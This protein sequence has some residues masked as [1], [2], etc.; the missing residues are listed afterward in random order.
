M[1]DLYA[2]LGVARG[3][4][5]TALKRAYRSKAKLLHPDTVGGD[6]DA[7]V[8]LGK[9][10]R[11]LSDSEMRAHYDATG[12]VDEEAFD[13]AER[14]FRQIL[15]DGFQQVVSAAG[16]RIDEIDII[17]RLKSAIEENAQRAFTEIQ[18]AK[19][20]VGKLQKLKSRITRDD[21]GRNFF[22][23]ALNSEIGK[24]DAAIRQAE[25][26]R[27]IL[28]LCLDEV[29]NYSSIVEMVQTMSFMWGSGSSTGT[30]GGVSWVQIA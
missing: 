25:R 3:C 18:G 21:G 7:F 23:D 16:P 13:R 20:Q 4:D 29:R 8:E 17:A 14:V 1:S 10:F 24:I 27:E 15:L 30:G 28:N 6:K 5:A 12:K 2:I 26:S 9:A 19:T 11:I 22:S